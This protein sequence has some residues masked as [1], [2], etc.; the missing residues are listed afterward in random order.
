MY[1][2]FK[3]PKEYEGPCSGSDQ[4]NIEG[5][6]YNSYYQWVPIFLMFLA[7]FFYLPRMMW[8]LMEGGLMKFFGKGTTTRLIE[9]PEEKR[10]RLVRYVNGLQG[11]QL[12]SWQN[13]VSPTWFFF[14]FVD[15]SQTTFTINTTFTITASYFAKHLTSSL[16]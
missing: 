7:V 9:E 6:I 13:S 2:H 1:A 15:F 3:I 10:D 12:F 11:C 8:M 14:I 4:S 16:W 5:P